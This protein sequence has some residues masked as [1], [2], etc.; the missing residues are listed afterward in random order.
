[1]KY[2]IVTNNNKVYN[3]EIPNTNIIKEKYEKAKEK[4]SHLKKSRLVCNIIIWFTA[5]LSV[6]EI[7]KGAIIALNGTNSINADIMIGIICLIVSQYINHVDNVNK[8]IQE[9]T[10]F[11][12][13]ALEDFTELE[14]ILSN[15]PVLDIIVRN[16][17][18]IIYETEN[19]IE[20]KRL[21]KNFSIKNNNIYFAIK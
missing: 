10:L 17:I 21:K 12:I 14:I 5:A 4:M 3:I 11:T 15:N 16:G 18:N 13:S 20:E 1:M 2:M 7:I 19:G 8:N 6:F 9:K